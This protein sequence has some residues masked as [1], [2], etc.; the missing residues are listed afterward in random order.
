M[1]P[2]L[3]R[4]THAFLSHFSLNSQPMK[5]RSADFYFNRLILFIYFNSATKATLAPFRQT[6]LKS[7]DMAFKDQRNQALLVC[8]CMFTTH[9]INVLLLF[10]LRWFVKYRLCLQV[11]AGSHGETDLFSSR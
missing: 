11:M 2:T 1:A 3:A 4:Q 5:L 10:I 9:N 8:F 7:G 6:A